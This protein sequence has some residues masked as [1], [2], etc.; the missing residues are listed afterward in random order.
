MTLDMCMTTSLL[1]CL[2]PF[3]THS[4]GELVTVLT[5]MYMIVL[6]SHKMLSPRNE[7]NIL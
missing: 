1:S 3:D 5:Y 6:A 2:P 7:H 4:L